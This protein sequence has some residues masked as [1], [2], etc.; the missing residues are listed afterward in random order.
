[1]LCFDQACTPWSVHIDASEGQSRWLTSIAPGAGS[2]IR[3][4]P[5]LEETPVRVVEVFG[6]RLAGLPDQ[7]PRSIALLN[8]SHTQ[9]DAWPSTDKWIRHP[10][11]LDV[12]G[13]SSVPLL[14]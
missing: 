11:L 12:R 4:P 3:F 10:L 7:L 2:S 5:L 1:M 14:P 9:V 13:V 6:R 8:L